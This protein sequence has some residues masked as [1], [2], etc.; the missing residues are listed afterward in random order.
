MKEAG[1]STTARFRR[2]LADLMLDDSFTR[3]LVKDSSGYFSI[4]TAEWDDTMGD[5]FEGIDSLDFPLNILVPAGNRILAF[6]VTNTAGLASVETNATVYDPT[7]PVMDFLVGV[8]RE[9]SGS[10]YPPGESAVRASDDDDDGHLYFM[11]GRAAA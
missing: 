9:G 4:I 11:F 6:T 10:L 5:V 7:A 1:A 8:M 3:E 2:R